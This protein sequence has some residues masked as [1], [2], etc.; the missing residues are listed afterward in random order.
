M[1]ENDFDGI[2]LLEQ[3]SE[4]HGVSGNESEVRKLLRTALEG[5]TDE[6]YTD[7]LGNLVAVKRATARDDSGSAAPLKVMLAAHMDEAGFMVVNVEGSGIVR[8]RKI[9]AH[10]DRYLLSLPV[11]IGQSKVTGIVG[12]KPVHLLDQGERQ[13]VQSVD[14]LGIDTGG[15]SEGGSG[16]RVG[17]YVT[18]LQSFEVRGNLVKGKA[19]DD[20]A[21][22]A[23]LV[24]LLR[25]AGRGDHILP[26]DLYVTFTVQEWVGSRGARVLAHSIAPDLTIAVDAAL[27]DDAP[28]SEKDQPHVRLNG[29]PAL[30]L[31]DRSM[32]ADKRVLRLVQEAAE[33]AGVPLQYKKPGMAMAGTDAGGIYISREGVPSAVLSLPCR[34]IP[35]PTGMMDLRDY[36]AALKLLLEL[37][38]GLNGD[39][40]RDALV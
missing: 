1:M 20:R 7:V 36:R 5:C 37:L 13:R 30:T 17:D 19:L 10:D 12:V 40:A 33:R 8:V 35:A 22:C 32:M 16:V 27:A 31:L 24:E 6:L 4:A 21:G 26:V 39:S 18:F 29:G 38:S 3:L 15:E 14:G 25:T 9:G 11:V 34:Y 2:K 23:L 28:A